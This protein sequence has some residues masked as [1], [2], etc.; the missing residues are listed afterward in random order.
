MVGRVVF[1]DIDGTLIESGGAGARALDRALHEVAGRGGSLAGVR[2]DGA[3]DIGLLRHALG[4]PGQELPQELVAAVFD[5]YVENLPS[6]LA[7]SPR[8]RLLPGVE[9][10]L[11][12]LKSRGAALGLCTGNVVGGAR[13]KLARGGLWEHFSF[14]GYGSDAEERADIV[15][16]ALR[17]AGEAV[18][19]EVP[20]GEALVVGDTPRDA[21]AARAAGV[22]C[23]GVATGRF[24][25]EE[26][27]EAG[28][29]RAVAS[30]E[31]EGLAEW[32]AG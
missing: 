25:V 28:A 3:T 9:R 1:F 5:R 2:F 14:G 27:E 20:P 6:E 17:R 29:E 7:A 21:V 16:A 31:V 4:R 22:P 19:R 30:L 23:L 11:Q 8:Y 26:L 10:L 18:G 32:I 12:A 15:R 13:A 24:T